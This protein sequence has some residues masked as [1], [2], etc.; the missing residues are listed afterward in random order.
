LGD[1]S[2]RA[3]RVH[4]T[5]VPQ[6]GSLPAPESSRRA[7]AIV[8]TRSNDVS[9]PHPLLGKT[10]RAL[11]VMLAVLAVPYTT[12]R[13][14]A[15]RVARAPW[16]PAAE[17]DVEQAVTPLA[18]RATPG[19]QALP[20]SENTPTVNNA[21][22]SESTGT[23]PDIDPDVRP[24]LRTVAIEDPGGHTLD[25]F[26]AR[27]ARTDRKEAGA[28]TRILHYGDSTIASD[29]VSGTVRRRMQ[30]RFGDAG[31]GFIL[32]AN[33]WEWYFHND[34]LHASDGE[35]KASR[36]A[37]PV[38]PDGMY[39]LGGVSFT[40][41]GGGVA[42]FGTAT[43]GDF[44][45][46]VSRFDLY[47]LEQPGGGDVELGVRGATPER[48]STRGDAKTS[49]VHSVHVDDGEAKLTVKAM[50]GGPVRLFGVA[51]E[52]DQPGVVY[53]ALGS[54][55]AMAVYWQ[56]QDAAHWKDQ[57]ALRDAAL[58]VFQYGTNESDL[59][60]LDRD[61][62]EKALA[63]LVDELREAAGGASILVVAPLD[64]AQDK[65]GRL[66][67]KSVILDLVAIQKRV[68]LSHGA[69]FWNT[70]DAMGGEG[71]MARWVKAK[72]QLGG[73]DLTHPTPLGAE[74]LGDM[75]SDA[76][77]AAFERYKTS[78][79]TATSDAGP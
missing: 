65:D 79:P 48:L 1:T 10:P 8:R 38:A 53:D 21:L 6:E 33:P 3:N 18:A 4:S 22:P 19:E 34:V 49:R 43:R 12:P 44:G 35:W 52:R 2:L 31:H 32:I 73:G 72:P 36:L 77:I 9:E 68:A 60:K 25:A 40:S 5:N 70:F 71:S 50:G 59:W 17:A 26:F 47:Y 46:H 69:A 64:R 55:A 51:L 39:G 74:V 78:R 37:G 7:F 11:L 56:R 13:L 14:R 30:A 23:L 61:D 63:G 41:Y 57:L 16:D 20:A 54:H 42:W 62:Y 76:L 29:Y 15:L 28:V 58:V 24:T 67:T 45:R 75:L 27:L 66:V